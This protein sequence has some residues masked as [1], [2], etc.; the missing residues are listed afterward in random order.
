MIDATLP[1]LVKYLTLSAKQFEKLVPLSFEMYQ[2]M[3]K[4]KLSPRLRARY[5]LLIVGKPS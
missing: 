4:A 1:E 5:L 2:A 3:Q